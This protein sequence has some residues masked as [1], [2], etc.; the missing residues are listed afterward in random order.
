MRHGADV[1]LAHGLTARSPVFAAVLAFGIVVGATAGMADV[2]NSPFLKYLQR[3]ERIMYVWCLDAHGKNNDFMAIVDVDPNSKDYGT[4]VKTIDLGS[5]DNE[6]H[7]FGFTDDRRYIYGASL[8]TSKLYL[9]DV[10]TNPD[11]PKLLKMI[12]FKRETGLTSPHSL[13]ALPGRMMIPSLGNAQG[14]VP[15]GIAEY[16]ND[17]KYIRTIMN[18]ADSPYGY[19]TGVKPEIDRL[20]SSGFTPLNNFSKPFPQMDKNHFGDQLILWD[21]SNMQPIATAK[22]GK[23]PLEI[24]WARQPGH[25]YGFTNCLLGDSIWLF[26]PTA[27]GKLEATE[28]VKTEPLPAD[29]RQTVDDKYLYVTS[30]GAGDVEQFDI[31]DPDHVTLHSKVHIG[32]HPNMMNI[33]TDGKRMFVTNSL[34]STADFGPDDFWMKLVR[35]DDSGIMHVDPK[36][37]VDFTKLPNGPGRPHD[38][39]EN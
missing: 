12:D 8:F 37:D 2:C 33:S 4:I 10:G 3:P 21:F 19:D 36:F 35:I 14:D 15:A 34:L 6:T 5:K 27:D 24:R 38:M 30:F 11:D 25:N 28:A 26:R 20:V 13:Y 22:T 23:S 29:L 9:F 32:A 39:L 17:G 18:P 31:S 7:H 1:A 16:T